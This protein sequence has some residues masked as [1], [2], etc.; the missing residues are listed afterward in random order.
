MLINF[1]LNNNKHLQCILKIN[2]FLIHQMV[3]IQIIAA[4]LFKEIYLNNNIKIQ[5]YC[6]LSLFKLTL[7]NKIIIIIIFKFKI[8]NKIFII[9]HHNNNKIFQIFK[10]NNLLKHSSNIIQINNN[11]HSYNTK[12]LKMHFFSSKDSINNLINTFNNH[13]NRFRCKIKP[14]HKDFSNN[15]FSNHNNSLGICKIKE[16]NKISKNYFE[17]NLFFL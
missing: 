11:N 15:K 10:H 3:F 9:H 6:S 5:L 1:R 17:E 13:N 8:H 14:F 2:K 16:I 4:L 7:S 12:C